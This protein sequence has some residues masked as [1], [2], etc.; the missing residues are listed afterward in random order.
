MQPAYDYKAQRW[1]TEPEAA[2][3]LHIEQG[4]EEIS[5]LKSDKAAHFLANTR[6]RHE[7]RLTP[8]EALAMTEAKLA[9]YR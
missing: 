9:D 6:K 5:L 8:A 4:E 1:V 7:P 2:R 3:R